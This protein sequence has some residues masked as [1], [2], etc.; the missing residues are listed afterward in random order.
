MTAARGR[1][2]V[3]DGDTRAG[4]EMARKEHPS[5][6]CVESVSSGG[7]ASVKHKGA[8][9]ARVIARD[10]AHVMLE[11]LQKWRWQ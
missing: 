4:L 2:L 5:G 8:A 11:W 10:D 6:E 1:V 3:L 7:R 9:E